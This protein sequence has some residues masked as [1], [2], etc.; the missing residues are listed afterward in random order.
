M[1]EQFR[2]LLT[3]LRGSWA[4]WNSVRLADL[5]FPQAATARMVVVAII[6]V[7]VAVLLLRMMVR[8]SAYRGRVALPALVAF[9][10]PSRGSFVRHGALLLG[11]AGLPFFIIALADPRT[12]VTREEVSYRA[13]ASA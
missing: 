11:L 12:A 2:A 7:A 6:G 13:A 10:T 1:T 4:D 3:V 9:S 8:A 5:Q